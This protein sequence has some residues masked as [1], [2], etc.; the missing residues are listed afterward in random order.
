M[1]R[2]LTSLMMGLATVVSAQVLDTS[3]THV[4]TTLNPGLKRIGTLV[5][6][7]IHEISGEQNWSM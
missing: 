2:Y 5:P 1:T 4:Q 6:R 7:S 3:E